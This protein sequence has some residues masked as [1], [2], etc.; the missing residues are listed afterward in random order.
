MGHPADSHGGM[1]VVI[2]VPTQYGGNV[3]N[4]IAYAGREDPCPS[5][6]YVIPEFEVGVL[7]CMKQPAFILAI[8]AFVW[9]ITLKYYPEV[10]F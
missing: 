3:G 4:S 10:R 1:E 5:Q 2:N 9:G 7:Y 8:F 6:M